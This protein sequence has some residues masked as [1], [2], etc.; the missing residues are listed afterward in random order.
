MGPAQPETPSHIASK[1]WASA[2]REREG[3]EVFKPHD[4]LIR[5]ASLKDHSV[6]YKEQ[7]YL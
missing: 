5:F 3:I 2:K 1:I 4:D 7:N 6:F